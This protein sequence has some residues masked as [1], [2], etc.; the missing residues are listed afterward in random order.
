MISA[1][2]Y[3]VVAGSVPT[4]AAYLCRIDM[5]RYALPRLA[6]RI[7][8]LGIDPQSGHRVSIILLHGCLAGA[9]I[10]AGT[11]A[12]DGQSDAGDLFAVAGAALWIVV[13]FTSWRTSVPAHWESAPVPLDEPVPTTLPP[14]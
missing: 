2:D 7:M 9:C 11:N 14:R 12:W 5:L 13:S 3:L 8:R 10:F 1:L 6:A 4:L